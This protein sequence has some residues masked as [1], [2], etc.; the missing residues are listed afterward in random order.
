MDVDH[1]VAYLS[2]K[3]LEQWAQQYAKPSDASETPGEEWLVFRVAG[4]RFALPVAVLERVVKPGVG[5]APP[6]RPP[7][8]IGAILVEG[9]PVP[10]WDLAWLMDLSSSHPSRQDCQ[11]LLL[12]QEGFQC[13]AM[14]FLVERIEPGLV[15]LPSLP[16]T[17]VMDAPLVITWVE[18]AENSMGLLNTA[19]LLRMAQQRLRPTRGQP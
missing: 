16:E 7:A 5:I 12:L 11:R 3:E 4:Q 9:K 2:Q 14:A 10:L 19:C 13:D 6:L 15:Y 8:L 17:G 1:Q 18:R